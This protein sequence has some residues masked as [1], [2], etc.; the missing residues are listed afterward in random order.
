LRIE[1]LGIISYD[2]VSV[3]SVDFKILCWGYG[4]SAF[5]VVLAIGFVLMPVAVLKVEHKKYLFIPCTYW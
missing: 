5:S 2:F 1:T 4:I 3:A